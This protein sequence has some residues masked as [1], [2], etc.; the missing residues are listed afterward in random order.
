MI[1][2]A[3]SES[4]DIGRLVLVDGGL[5]RW[6]RRRDGVVTIRE[7]LVLPSHRRKGVGRGML[8]QVMRANPDRTL[9]ARCP[10]EYDAGNAFWAAMAFTLIE[11]KGGLNLWQRPANP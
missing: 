5:C 2:V 3:L 11:V 1:F 8:V 7:I 9:R 4:A 10:V 6:H